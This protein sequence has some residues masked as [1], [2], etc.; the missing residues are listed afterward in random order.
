MS[1]KRMRKRCEGSFKARVALAALPTNSETG[2]PT[3]YRT[4]QAWPYRLLAGCGGALALMQSC[5]VPVDQCC[6]ASRSVL[7]CRSTLGGR[8]SIAVARSIIGSRCR[9]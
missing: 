8:E 1:R 2:S 7:N 3:D 9:N 6:P 4:R 5:E